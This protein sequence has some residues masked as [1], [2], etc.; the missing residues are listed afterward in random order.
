M[1]PCSLASPCFST[2]MGRLWYRLV[3][4]WL[5][6]YSVSSSNMLSDVQSVYICVVCAAVLEVKG[7]ELVHCEVN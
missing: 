3:P 4:S 6:I 5:D 7:L 2:A 1:A